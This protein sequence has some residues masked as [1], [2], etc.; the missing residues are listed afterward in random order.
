MAIKGRTSGA[1]ILWVLWAAA[2]VFTAFLTPP[3]EAAGMIW[4]WFLFSAFITVLGLIVYLGHYMFLAGINT[5]TE[6]ERSMYDLE[7]I[8]SFM[9]IVLVSWSYLFFLIMPAMQIYGMAGFW[10]MTALAL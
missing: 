10:I 1:L 3:G 2:A 7:K 4:V 5:M 6:K 8:S 9:G